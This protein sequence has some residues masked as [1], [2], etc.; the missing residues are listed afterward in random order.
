[1]RRGSAT[2]QV[3][4]IDHVVIRAKDLEGMLAFYTG[5]L[6]CPV[7]RRQKAIGLV[8]LRAG[9][10]LIDLVPVDGPLGRRGGPP[11]G[12]DG[13]NMDHLCLRVAAF[14]AGR[15][16]AELQAAGVEVGENGV[17]YGSSG[18]AMSLYLRD[19]DGNALELR[20]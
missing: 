7:E 8:Q 2:M 6:G 5:V 12:A 1:M 17:R 3:T 13:H 16:R 4:G 10:C 9:A 14:D 18:E 11:P 20:G 19:P 15:L